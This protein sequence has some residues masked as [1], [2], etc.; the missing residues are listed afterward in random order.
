[1]NAA[2][3]SPG[4]LPVRDRSWTRRPQSYSQ[5]TSRRGRGPPTLRES[6][7]PV[8]SVGIEGE[9]SDGLPRGRA[10]AQE[11]KKRSTGAA[12]RDEFL[13][14]HW[15]MEVG[16]LDPGRLVF[17]DEMGT[18]TSL[19]PLYAYAPIGERVFFKIPRNRG[20]NTTLLTSLHQG[21]IG[22]SMAVEGATPLP[23]SSRRT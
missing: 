8:R 17:V 5:K 15:R 4:R 20:K 22:P 7:V 23:G 9:R 16:C 2:L 18:H 14:A 21:G 1:M 12:E 6:R 19:A 13:R 3:C 10:P 11:P